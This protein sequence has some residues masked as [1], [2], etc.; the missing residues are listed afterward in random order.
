[1][2]GNQLENWIIAS[3][4]KTL[5]AAIVPVTLGSAV[6]WNQSLFDPIPALFA[7]ICALL[8]QI[9]TNFANDYFD[10]KSGAD[11]AERIGFERV[12]SS[13]RIPAETVYKA[14]LISFGL[15][16]LLGLYLVW[17]AGWIVLLIGILCLIFGYAYTGGP[18]PLGYNG[19]GDIFVFIFFGFVSVMTTFYV[20]ALH[21]SAETF[22]VAL[23]AGALSTNILVVNN[24]RDVET[25]RL[26]GKKTLGVIFGEKTLKLEYSLLTLLALSIP[27]HLY[28]VEGYDL[29][30]FLPFLTI[31]LMLILN[32]KVWNFGNR[33]S[34]NLVLNRT[35]GVMTLFG[36]LLSV[37][38]LLD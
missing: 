8:I 33:A 37:G 28:M 4:P 32:L 3:R 10:F 2:S 20:Q 18:F 27:P 26:S 17:H 16:F 14:M 19:L 7:L 21:W 6:A 9:G 38:I 25:D 1:M 24:L 34:L 36:L 29:W 31:P 5:A 15:A 22:W 13:G 35:A 12:S 23:A 30:I 11:N